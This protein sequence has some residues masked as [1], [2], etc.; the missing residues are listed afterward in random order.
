MSNRVM[1][2]ACEAKSLCV[3]VHPSCRVRRLLELGVDLLGRSAGDRVDRSAVPIVECGVRVCLDDGFDCRR[4]AF[5]SGSRCG[6]GLQR[7]NQRAELIQL[8]Q[9]GVD[10]DLL[11]P[12]GVAVR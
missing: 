10:L 6:H 8:D 7:R 11:K 4:S 2:C 9:L 12:G 1:S 5:S 3:M